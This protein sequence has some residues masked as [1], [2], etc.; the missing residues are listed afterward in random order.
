LLVRAVSVLGGAQINNN[1]ARGAP[2][3]FFVE[4]GRRDCLHNPDRTKSIKK[5]TKA[6]R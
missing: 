4:A 1:D 3:T 2:A 5:T 6:G